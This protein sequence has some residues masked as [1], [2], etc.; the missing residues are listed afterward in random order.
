MWCWR[1]MEKIK[2]SEK[3]T[4]EEISQHTGEK[5]M[6]LNNILGSI[7]NWIGHINCL[8]LDAIQGQITEVKGPE[9]KIQ[10]LVDLRNKKIYLELKEKLKIKKVETTVYHISIR[11]K[12][13]F[14]LIGPM[15]Y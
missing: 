10:L 5:R 2:W 15:I 11:N 14:S 8:L 12:C 9:R 7:A 3:V 6:L 4:N 1:R 13:K